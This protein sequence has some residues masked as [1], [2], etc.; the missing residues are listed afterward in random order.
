[1]FVYSGDQ[2]VVLVSSDGVSGQAAAI[3]GV[4]EPLGGGAQTQI[5]FT[6][7]ASRAGLYYGT[8]QVPEQG[9]YLVDITTPWDARASRYAIKVYDK[10]LSTIEYLGARG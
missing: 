4:I 6:E 7:D 3:S 9:V 5:V 8:A 10:P 1:M 2:L